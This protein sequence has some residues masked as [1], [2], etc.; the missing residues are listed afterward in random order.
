MQVQWLRTPPPGRH[1]SFVPAALPRDGGPYFTYFGTYTVSDGTTGCFYLV[2]TVNG[3]D[4]SDK[5]ASIALTGQPRIPTTGA[6]LPQNFGAIKNIMLK[7]QP[8]TIRE[9]VP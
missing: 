1:R 7:L 2:T 5:N 4:I 6:T 8:G 9:P 3:D